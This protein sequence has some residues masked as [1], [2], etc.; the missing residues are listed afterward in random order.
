MFDY[1]YVRVLQTFESLL[2]LV[3]RPSACIVVVLMQD[4]S[5]YAFVLIWVGDHS[6]LNNL[7]LTKQ[8]FS[9]S[10][11]STRVSITR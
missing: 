7:K 11:T 9:F 3:R 2:H 1:E 10:Q 8:H 6:K 4:G 5:C